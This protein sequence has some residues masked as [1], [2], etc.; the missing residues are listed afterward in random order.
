MTM[1]A[2]MEVCTHF[3]AKFLVN[4]IRGGF[5][6]DQ[7][8]I[9]RVSTSECILS[10]ICNELPRP[11]G[12]ILMGEDGDFKNR[13]IGKLLRS[14]LGNLMMG[15]CNA[16][17]SDFVQ[18]NGGEVIL[19][20]DTEQSQQRYLRSMCVQKMHQGGAKTVIG[21][22]VAWSALLEPPPDAEEMDY[23]VTVSEDTRGASRP[24]IAADT[25]PK[26][27]AD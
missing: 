14:D 22:Y 1:C 2:I 6:M 16:G 12:I 4:F 17:L 13:I 20:L 5:K 23:L 18:F 15:Y 11:L 8:E 9:R 25:R 3:D 10:K 7:W 24:A 27:I 21:I 26:I 19:I